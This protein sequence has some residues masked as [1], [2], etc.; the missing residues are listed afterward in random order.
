MVVVVV[1][2]VGGAARSSASVVVVVI[3]Y[4]VEGASSAEVREGRVDIQQRLR[5]R[6]LLLPAYRLAGR[7]PALNTSINPGIQG[8]MP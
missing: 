1:V 4:V 8:Y 7:I 5:T 2:E 6:R 3:V